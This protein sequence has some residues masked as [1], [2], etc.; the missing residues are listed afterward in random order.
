MSDISIDLHWQRK[1]PELKPGAYSGEHTVQFNDIFEVQV[2]AAPDYRG[3]ASCTNPEQALASA[4]SIAA[5]NRGF[6]AV[7]FNHSE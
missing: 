3:D 5:R 6:A 1:E 4:L 2:D 7:Q